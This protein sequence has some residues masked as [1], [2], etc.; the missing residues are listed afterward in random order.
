MWYYDPVRKTCGQFIYSGCL[1]N[2]NRFKNREDCED[3]CGDS[4]DAG[5]HFKYLNFSVVVRAI[6]NFIGFFFFHSLH[7]SMH[8]E[9][10]ARSLR[11]QLH[12]VVFQQ[13][14]S[15]LRNFHLRWL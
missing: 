8:F 4:A 7:R 11:R 3:Q 1:G 12:E 15:D 13:R 9:K 5:E 6:F 10:R 14:N 2:A